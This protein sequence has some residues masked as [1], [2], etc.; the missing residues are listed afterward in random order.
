[1]HRRSHA[2]EQADA[3]LCERVVGDSAPV[4]TLQAFP[5]LVTSAADDGPTPHAPS[6]P[7]SS[8]TA[9]ASTPSLM[10]ERRVLVIATRFPPAASVGATR[11]RKHVKYL[12]DFGWRPV[13]LTGALPADNDG[14]DM[15]TPGVDRQSLFDVPTD[16]IVHR[17]GEF[18]EN[19]PKNLSAQVGDWMD[20]LARMTSLGASNW[21]DRIA[22]RL[23]AFHDRFAFPDRGIWRI[24]AAVRAALRLHRHHR[25]D[26]IYS[27]GMPFSD[28]LIALAVRKIICRPW[29]AEFRDP[30]VEYIHWD[31][32]NSPRGR[33]LAERAEAAVM[34]NASRVV[35]V[36]DAMTAR[37]AERYAT[38]P[39]RKFVTVENGFDPSDFNRD[40]SDA[41]SK[42]AADRFRLVYAG[43]LYDTR[44]PDVVLEGFRRFLEGNPEARAIA[45]FDFY[46]R[47]GP[48]AGLLDVP[49]Y[50]NCVRHYGLVSHAMAT[51]AML[52]ADVN[53]VILPKMSGGALD[54]TAKVYECLGSGRP[55]LAVVPADGAA[56]K[57]LAR[58]QGVSI[59]EPDDA[60]AIAS[61]I[62]GWF[63][64]RIANSPDQVRSLSSLAPLTRRYQTG[65]LAE[66]MNEVAGRRRKLRG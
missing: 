65:R 58:F 33:R 20:R 8:P 54:S 40:E 46:G 30:W 41:K 11:I 43:S 26:A 1:M 4:T 17:L 24:G 39:R 28:H 57:T 38:I 15:A 55:I 27:S 51:Q 5:R 2:W 29:I 49:A 59:C 36:N 3:A 19:W 37:F 66:I 22:W 63:A 50:S 44:R 48:H 31:Q 12:G 34:R 45:T 21:V 23:Q 53:V 47:V 18:W 25:F 64:R 61:A 16:V 32:W 9:G 10:R 7:L 60:A 52:E 6:E 14:L 35:S 62:A 42:R 56:A 13:V